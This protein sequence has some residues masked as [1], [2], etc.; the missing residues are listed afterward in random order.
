MNKYKGV[1]LALFAFLA[2]VTGCKKNDTTRDYNFTNNINKVVTL[3]IY[4]SA[5]DYAHNTNVMLRKTLQPNETT[6][7][8]ASTFK[9]GSTYYMD[10]YTDDF[11]Y[12]NWFNIN[13]PADGT[14]PVIHPSSSNTAFYVKPDFHNA[15]RVAFLKGNQDST[16]WVAIGAYL[17]SN[18]G[19]VDEWASLGN[20]GQYRELTVRKDFNASYSYK[21]ASGNIQ[22]DTLGFLVH[23]ANV[24]YL[25]FVN[26]AGVSQ[27]SM[28]GSQFPDNPN[29]TATDRMMVLLPNSEMYFLMVRQ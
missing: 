12:N 2:I 11:V 4:T 8:A 6:T 21:D 26:A 16:H 7:L 22:V 13:F 10:Y 5:E 20:N 23:N 24:P 18:N 29:S 14:S 15:N 3:D 25:E 1:L 9:S 28:I 19:Y 17:E 27:G